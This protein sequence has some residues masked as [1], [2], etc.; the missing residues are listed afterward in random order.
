MVLGC[1]DEVLGSGV[2]DQVYPC[3]RVEARCGEVGEG[4]VV[5]PVFAVGAQAVVEE[6]GG[7]G[8]GVVR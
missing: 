7:V 3:F 8:L 4:V 6:V 1:Y 2:G 5:G